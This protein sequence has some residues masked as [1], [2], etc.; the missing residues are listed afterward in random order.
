VLLLG[1]A[2]L[3][4]LPYELLGV[5]DNEGLVLLLGIAPLGEPPYELLGVEPYKLD[6]LD[7]GL[8]DGVLP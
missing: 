2:P 3:G 6:G 7:D 1:I 5:E 8:L 4:E